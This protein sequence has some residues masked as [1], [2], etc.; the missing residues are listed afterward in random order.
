[1]TDETNLKNIFDIKIVTLCGSAKFEKEFQKI[2]EILTLRNYVVFSLGIFSKNLPIKEQ[3]IF[4]KRY[5]DRLDN[6][7]KKKIDLADIIFVMNVEGYIG[8]STREE[9]EYAKLTGKEIFYYTEF[10]IKCRKCGSEWCI[11][12]K[13]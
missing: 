1:M 2:N 10:D 9:I 8:D 13:T 3:E 12:D 5:K 6:I 11:C 7:H 4:L